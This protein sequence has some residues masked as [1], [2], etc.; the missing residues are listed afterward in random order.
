MNGRFAFSTDLRV[1]P[2]RPATLSGAPVHP[3]AGAERH[4]DADARRR[5]VRA[6]QVAPRQPDG[7]SR[8]SLRHRDHADPERLQSVLCEA[9]TI[10]ST[11]TTS[12]RGSA[13]RGGRVE[14]DVA[15]ARRL[16]VV[17][18]QD[19]AD[20][21]DAVPRSGVYSD[22]FI[23]A[24]PTDRADP[25]PSSGR[26][27]TDPI[28]VNG[29]VVNRACDQRAVP[30]R[31]D[32][33]QHRHGLPRQPRSERAAGPAADTGI[34]AAAGAQMA[35]TVDYVHSWN[36]DQLI[37]YDLNPG[38]RVNTTRTGGVDEVGSERAGVAAEQRVRER[39][40]TPVEAG[41]VQRARA[42]RPARRAAAGPCPGAASRR[43]AR[44]RA[45]RTAGAG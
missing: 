29:P 15:G 18:R 21:D 28:L 4:P 11:R 25:G 20:H 7:Q 1:Q 12:R 37:N 13:S 31:I 34:R 42:G 19:H 6:G 26:L 5:A 41:G 45:A 10:P 40:V 17:L 43:T 32:R 44:G 2:E 14:R 33:P 9:A 8:R 30:T 38:P 22:S 16:R 36:R 24:F 39:A 35:V 23:A 27:P 3:R